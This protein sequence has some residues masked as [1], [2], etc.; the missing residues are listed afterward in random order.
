MV[1]GNAIMP[2]TGEPM[3]I[4]NAVLG[5][6][7]GVVLAHWLP[8]AQSLWACCMGAGVAIAVARRARILGAALV[9]IGW[10]GV[11]AL[12]AL[13][14][15]ADPDCVEVTVH[16]R[17]AGLPSVEYRHGMSSQ[18]FVFV[19]E[20]SGCGTGCGA[21]CGLRG[22][23]RLIWLDG[24]SLRGGE[25][26]SLDVRLKPP[27]AGANKHGFD[28]EAWF[29]RDKVAATGYVRRGTRLDGTDVDGDP[30]PWA[31][32]Q[33]L[34]D[35]LAELPLVHGDVLAA[36][37]LGHKGAIHS[38]KVDLY[39]RTGTMH[40]LVIS[41][42]HVGIVTAFGF[43]AGRAFGQLTTLSPRACG[44]VAALALSGAYVVLAGS[45]LS[46]VRAF[47][48]SVAGMVA[49]IAGRPSAPSGAFAYA[50]GV[51]LLV[52]PMAPLG[53]GFWLSFGAVAV[54]LGFFVPRPQRWPW[55]ISALL[56]QLA[57]ATV[58]VPATT[59]ITGLVHPL[60][61]GVN[62]VAVPTVTLLVVPFALAGVVSLATPIGPWLLTAADFVVHLLEVILATADRIAPLYVADHDGWHAWIV[63]A[64]A[65]GLLPVSRIARGLLLATVVV[66]LFLPQPTLPRGQVAVTVLDVGQG[67]AVLVETANHTMIYDT[68]PAF[69]SGRDSGTGVVL[70]AVRGRGW[71]R[72]DRLVLSHGDVDHIGGAASVL[73]GLPVG[74]VL[75][76]EAI[77]GIEAHPCSA[78]LNWH[79]DGVG[80]SILSPPTDHRWTGNNASCVVLIETVSRRVLLAGDIEAIVEGRLT[81]PLVDV[82]LVPHHG[83]AT[84]STAALVAATKPKFAVVA[85]GF[86]NRFGHPH[87]QVV[88]R[89]RNS[90]S[91]IV[92]TALAGAV[93]WRSSHPES[94]IVQRC[95]ASPYWRLDRSSPSSTTV[96]C[97]WL[98][99]GTSWRP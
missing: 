68:G 97:D 59:G 61:I 30:S 8:M 19:P 83:S 79:W 99:L 23:L 39:R 16:G 87:P 76:G 18:R 73:D 12:D 62:L 47:A 14:R 21:S 3:D 86:D 1:A 22:A 88:Q 44:V 25:R 57:I 45:G 2:G 43:L 56:A 36:L 53:A 6:S 34:R 70:P 52:D 84:S 63:A 82:L 13:E 65:A 74:Q 20:D 60:G 67:T 38:D 33:G 28:A 17:V 4:R 10:G 24:P 11:N 77:P 90:G 69:P 15:R 80:F 71:G 98:A 55:L 26:W 78:G 37:T 92:S 9:G 96:A 66:M 48:M 91:H 93:S 40:L 49:L 58:F 85:A 31:I 64:A 27:R 46:L 95:S 5:F 42:L 89:Y 29:A 32:R 75:V 50:L 35:R 54:L 72:V 81:P 94:V 51:V 7:F 41:G